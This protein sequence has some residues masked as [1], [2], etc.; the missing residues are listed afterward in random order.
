MMG[1]DFYDQVFTKKL[2][3]PDELIQGDNHLSDMARFCIGSVL[4]IGC[5]MG[6]LANLIGKRVYTGIDFSPVA[7]SYAI[8]NCQN[9]NARFICLSFDEMVKLGRPADTVVLSEVLEHLENPGLIAGYAIQN[10]QARIVASVPV[11]MPLEQHVKADWSKADI[12]KLFGIKPS[13]ITK[14][15]INSKGIYRHWH[16]IFDWKEG[17]HERK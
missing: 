9:P 11:H 17:Y 14:G 16:M 7:I 15:C 5:G 2:D 10:A 12:E 6:Q 1:V 3:L 4:D 8:Q 13:Q